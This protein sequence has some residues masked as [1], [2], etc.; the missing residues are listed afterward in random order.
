M[1]SYKSIILVLFITFAFFKSIAQESKVKIFPNRLKLSFET[2]S[3]DREE[4]LG[5]AGIGLDILQLNHKFKSLYFGIHTY[6]AM[7]GNRPGLI[8]LGA[9][10][11]LRFPV[12]KN[13]YIDASGFVGGGGGG[14]AA[15]GGGLIIRP[16]IGFE[17]QLKNIGLTLGISYL[18]FPT[19]EISGTQLSFGITFNGKSYFEA[20]NPNY[21]K[22]SAHASTFKK[23]RM[24]LSNT[25]YTKFTNGSVNSFSNTENN[26]IG[27]IGA[28]L[29]RDLFYNFYAIGKINGA[30]SGG[31][32]GYMSILL[33]AGYKFP[34]L[35]KIISIETRAL[36]GPS[37]GGEVES[38]GG[39]TLQ[40]EGGASLQIFKTYDIKLMLGKTLA[41][42]GDF[43][44]QHFEV[45]LGKNFEV[46]SPKQYNYEEKINS[47]NYQF[48][49]NH[50]AVSLLNRTYFS[51]DATTKNNDPYE[52]SFN[53]IGFR[54]E[55]FFTSQLSGTA[56]TIWAYQGDYGAY[57]EGLIGI[58]YYIPILKKINI[59]FKGMFGAAG[60][61]G[62]DVGSGLITQFSSGINYQLTKNNNV[63][64]QFGKFL[65]IKGNFDPTFLDVGFTINLSQF[66]RKN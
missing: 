60:G 12:L 24:A 23:I 16:Y 2:V 32:D 57:A 1:R 7:S 33:G 45:S 28:Q 29:E 43:N 56:E 37:G 22:E 26:P 53:L 9:T 38:G 44:A 64:L 11:G 47:G 63:F 3:M 36:F 4:D 31:A 25:Y 50:L 19:G 13:F 62:I 66:F 52:S 41:P 34:I 59:P 40:L 21:I 48:T 30:L 20:N 39:A 58:T 51:P 18:D 8:T 6:S 10:A 54:I 27:L 15:D 5:F 46:L 55:N 42:W 17:K 35:K 61:G 65:P 14:N 49:K